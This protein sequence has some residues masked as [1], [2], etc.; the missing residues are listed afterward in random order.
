[1]RDFNFFRPYLD[2]ESL[3]LKTRLTIVIASILIFVFM[4]AIFVGNSVR[5]VG[6]E[7]EIKSIENIMTSP[8]TQQIK[9]EFAAEGE[10]TKK[11]QQYYE[12]LKKVSSTVRSM[13]IINSELIRKISS[14]TPEKVF[15][16]S[17]SITDKAVQIQCSSDSRISAAE[18]LHN[19]KEL[20]IFEEV[21]MPGINSGSEDND[22]QQKFTLICTLKGGEVNEEQN[23]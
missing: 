3:S 13:D 14:T 23:K 11:T 20:N 21:F 18:L 17:I 9:N 19:M 15:F 1:M 22:S 16:Q 7:K 8:K 10:K 5:I 12:E 4:A 2:N 6:I